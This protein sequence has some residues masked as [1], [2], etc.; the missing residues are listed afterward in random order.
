MGDSELIL[1]SASG[2]V[3]AKEGGDGSLVGQKEEKL[4]EDEGREN[5]QMKP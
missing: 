2:Q 5:L 3:E 1:K 4:V